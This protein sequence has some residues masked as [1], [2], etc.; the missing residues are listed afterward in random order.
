MTANPDFVSK[1]PSRRALL[2]SALGAAAATV[3][4]LG[5]PAAVRA[6]DPD[7][8]Q[9][10]V[11]NPVLATTSLTNSGNG[12]TALKGQNGLSG[13]GVW[14]VSSSG[15]GV[16]GSSTSGVGVYGFSISDTGVI[17]IGGGAGPGQPAVLGRGD[18]GAAGVH[19]ISGDPGLAP[20]A[21]PKVGV[22][23]YAAQDSNAKGVFGETTSGHAVHGAATTGF[24]GYFAGKVYTTKW[25]ELTE[26]SP[27][28]APGANKAR[29]F[30]KD[31]GSGR[32]QLCVRFNTGAVQV[33]ATQ[34]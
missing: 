30:L 15:F 18:A 12:A 11:D 29:L 17:G 10:G 6:H 9:K 26:I 7:D 1:S 19:G 4:A 14:G 16:Q 5:R 8:V 33:L 28:N 27:P 2:A 21:P 3:A 23:G 31:N 13:I 34:P 25:Y 22:Y 24:G 32:T 20:V